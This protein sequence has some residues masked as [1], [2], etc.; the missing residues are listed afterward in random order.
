MAMSRFE[1]TKPISY[2]VN[3]HKYLFFERVMNIF[4]ARAAKKQSQ[5]KPMA[6]FGS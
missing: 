5:S 3:G 2:E 4:P 6:G 1:K